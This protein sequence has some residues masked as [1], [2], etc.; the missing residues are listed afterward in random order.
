MSDPLRTAL[1][2]EVPEAEPAVG[3]LRGDLDPFAA[4][5]V[6]A[7][8]TVL[9]PFAPAAP[10]DTVLQSVQAVLDQVTAF[11]CT[12]LV[13]GWFDDRVL[14]L[15]PAD[16]AP[17]VDLTQRLADAFPDY[18]PYGAAFAEVVPHLTVGAD[19]PLA[20]LRAAEVEVLSRLPITAR[21]DTVSLLI[22]QP[23]RRWRRA[24]TFPLAGNTWAERSHRASTGPTARVRQ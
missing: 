17:F 10:V 21:V 3:A 11:D 12:L 8:L 20:A 6:P 18:P 14:W 24:R 5:G 2:V 9:S 13:T 16:P 1:V 23:D 4:L 7:H 22:E 15:G 19:A